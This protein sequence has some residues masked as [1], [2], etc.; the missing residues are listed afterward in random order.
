MKVFNYTVAIICILII[1]GGITG[2]VIQHQYANDIKNSPIPQKPY[3]VKKIWKMPSDLKEISG[4]I[5]IEDHKIACIEDEDGIIFIYDLDKNQI[6]KKIPF[7]DSGDFEAI[8]INQSDAYVMRSDGVVFEIKNYLEENIEVSKFETEFSSKNNMESL[9]LDTEKQQL[10]T[11]P[12]DKDLKTDNYKGLYTISLQTKEVKT[13]SVLKI[14]MKD[15]TFEE[16]QRKKLYKTFYPSDLAI[17]PQTGQ[18]YILDGRHSNLL[19]LNRSGKIENLVILNEELFPQPEGLTFSPTG[20]LY[21]STE[22]K[23]GEAA[24]MEVATK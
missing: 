7:A 5:W 14:N 15:D 19:I 23:K 20:R 21:I 3:I 17:H 2:F 16:F 6:I 11:I 18:F 9:A 13:E 1:G 24:I 4:V 22:G 10:I 8:T 12:K